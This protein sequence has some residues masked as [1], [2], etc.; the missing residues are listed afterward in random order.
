MQ[1][2]GP[3]NLEAIESLETLRSR[4]TT[5]YNQYTDLLAARKGIQKIIERVNSDCKRLF[6]ET[7]N[8]VRANFGTIFQK[9]FGGGKADLTLENPS[10]P[11]EGGVEIVARPPGKE[12]RS[13]SLM[14]GGEKS[15]TCVALL[16]AIF[17]AHSSPICILDEVDAALDEANIHRFANAILDFV[18][19]TQFLV[20][21]HSKKTTSTAK[22]IYGVTMEESGVSK[23]LSVHF[24]DV[25]DDGEILLQKPSTSLKMHDGIRSS[26]A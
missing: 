2:L 9:L 26:G 6:E 11:L 12:L 20:V 16:L 14:S 22:S 15:L 4:Y 17:Q 7:F 5:L 1:Q 21:T 8:A 10:N 25:G 13:L 24:D 3:V 23:I 19:K 18:P